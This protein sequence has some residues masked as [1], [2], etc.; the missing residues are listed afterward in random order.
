MINFYKILFII[1]STFLF[2][3]ECP[4]LDTLNINS[5][6][7]LWNIPI[8]NNWNNVEVMSWNIK[9]FPITN[10]T[11]DYVTEIITDL[12]PDII[13]FQEINDGSAFNSL[14]NNIPAYEFISS[15]S[16]L[17]F[18]VR[19]DVIEIVSWTT[20]FSQYGYEFAWRYP[21]LI[22]LKWICGERAIS[23]NMINIHLKSGG[24]EDDF[25]RRYLS[26]EYL[27][28]YINSH[29]G[30]LIILGDF[31]D[32]IIDQQN[33]NSLWPLVSA[34]NITFVTESIANI[35]YYATFPSWPSFIDHI[36]I[37]NSFIDV[38]EYN[39]IKTIRLDDYTGYSTYQ[40]NIS[41]HR[42]ILY[43]LSI[44]EIAI[45]EGIIIN[46]IM[47]NPTLVS[48]ATGEWF[49]IIN[50]SNN[51]INLNGII[52][53]DLSGDTH[54]ISNNNLV[55]LP[56]EIFV[57]GK[58][59]DYNINGGVNVDY[60]YSNFSLSNLWD[61]IIIEHPSGII[62]DEVHYDNGENFPDEAG[63]SM[64]L[65][66]PLL[67]NNSG[68][69]WQS[70]NIMYGNGDYGT[71]GTSNFSCQ[72]PIGDINQDSMYDILDIIILINCVLIDN[73]NEL[74]CLGD[75]NLDNNHNILDIVNLANCVLKENCN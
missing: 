49:E 42:P 21:M 72:E 70:A 24:D 69:N 25:N 75:M 16:G 17:A 40:N 29:T 19:T 60:V 45:P 58:N 66:N 5:T 50:T 53:K 57:L 32:E 56:N 37:S 71:P 20:I 30:N 9:N 35:D 28:Q 26:C 11:I 44:N 65:I 27:L 34:E 10:N 48:D 62:I 54:T 1:Y 55:M 73:C 39:Y 74:G 4:P 18:A 3:Q 52:I 41:D 63:K 61:E 2:S 67:D 6:Q 47:K 31:N 64:M 22:E 7:N 13:A 59:S 8:E 12:L 38:S 15:G 36:A 51:Q 68:Q 46:E 14:S 23:F 43:S 33:Y